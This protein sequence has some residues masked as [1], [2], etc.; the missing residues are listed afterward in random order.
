VALPGHPWYGRSV[1]ILGR[2]RTA[3]TI[4]C[5]IQDG[6]HPGFHYQVPERW[7]LSSPPPDS[8]W[9]LTCPTVCLPLAALDRMVQIILLTEHA[10]RAGEDEPRDIHLGADPNRAQGQTELPPRAPRP[11]AAEGGEPA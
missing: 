11:P 1:Q 2:R 8:A 5:I 9:M 10:R 4:R 3:T 6:A 7:L